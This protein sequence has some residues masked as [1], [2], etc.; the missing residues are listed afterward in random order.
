MMHVAFLSR[1]VFGLHSYGGM[2]RHVLEL[3]RHLTRAN[4]RV[5][6]IT[7]PPTRDAQW[8]EPGIDLKIVETAR[9]PVRGIADRVLNYP[10]WSQAAARVAAA[11][12]VDLAH[13]QGVGGYGYARLLAK[14]G[15]RAPLIINPQG[16]EE[17]KTTFAKR[18]AYVPLHAAAR[19]AA[20]CAH[21]LIASDTLTVQDIPRFLRVPPERV[22]LIPNGI[23]VDAARNWV[24]IDVQRVLVQR[25]QL[26]QRLP[27]LLSVGRLEQNKGFAVMLDALARIRS[28]LPS[29][30]LWLLVGE[31]PERAA[32]QEKIRKYQFRDHVRLL[33]NVDDI[34]LHNL[35]ELATLFVHPTLFEG[36]SL[37]TLEAM[38]HAR[39]LVGT[40]VGGI[41]DKILRGQNGYLVPPGDA[42]ALA[43]KI[44]LALR[45]PNRLRGM[46]NVSYQIA[47]ERFDWRVVLAQ[48]LELYQAVLPAR[49]PQPR[50]ADVPLDSPL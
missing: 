20:K 24:S 50:L 45:D 43:D 21:A 40:L 3:A 37:V 49:A 4:V 5:T 6:I 12:P 19:Y 11:L 36:S 23:D 28:F 48:T 16:M 27:L 32:L 31:G 33:G 38:C 35:Y 29:K 1:A 39:P 10:R 18:A 15:A 41:P 47:R 34:S 8:H 44:L 17:F 2:E 42:Q 26:S 9:V 7:M 13:A 46:G 22:V 25:L 14:G 30:W